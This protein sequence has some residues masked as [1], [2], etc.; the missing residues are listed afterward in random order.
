MVNEMV[1]H[2]SRPNTPKRKRYLKT[3]WKTAKRVFYVL[4]GGLVIAAWI[5]WTSIYNADKKKKADIEK[6]GL[7]KLKDGKVKTYSEASEDMV[8]FQWEDWKLDSLK[9]SDFL[10][11]VLE[12]NG[13]DP[14]IISS[15]HPIT[16]MTNE[17]ELK[18]EWLG[19]KAD[20]W[21]ENRWV[22][23]S[24]HSESIVWKLLSMW[25]N[26]SYWR[27]QSQREAIENGYKNDIIRYNN[28]CKRIANFKLPDKN[29]DWTEMYK[30]LWYSTDEEMIRAIQWNKLD[31]YTWGDRLWITYWIVLLNEQL[32]DRNKWWEKWDEDEVFEKTQWIK[33]KYFA[34][35]SKEDP[36]RQA[37]RRE[38]TDWEK[39]NTIYI[40][41]KQEQWWSRISLGDIK[42]RFESPVYIAWQTTAW[43]STS[44]ESWKNE[45]YL[46]T[47]Q[48]TELNQR[49]GDQI[50]GNDGDLKIEISTGTFWPTSTKLAVKYLKNDL[51]DEILKKTENEKIF[52]DKSFRKEVKDYLNAHPSLMDD[53]KNRAIEEYIQNFQTFFLLNGS[54]ETKE[55]VSN[56]E[57]FSEKQMNYLEQNLNLSFDHLYQW[58]QTFKDYV[59]DE[60]T[61]KK[62]DQIWYGYVRWQKK[63][64]R[65]EIAKILTHKDKFIEFTWLSEKEYNFFIKHHLWP[66][67]LWSSIILSETWNITPENQEPASSTSNEV[68][69][70]Y[71]FCAWTE[72]QEHKMK[73]EQ[74]WIKTEIK[75]SW[76]SNEIN[77]KDIREAIS[78]N[79]KIMEYI[80]EN[81][82]DDEW[83]PITDINQ[84]SDEF[85]YEFLD[86]VVE[87]WWKGVYF[88]TSG[89]NQ[90]IS[91]KNKYRWIA[92]KWDNFCDYLFDLQQQNPDFSKIL[93][94][95]IWKDSIE[96]KDITNWIIR[97][98]IRKSDWSIWENPRKLGA[99]ED[100]II[101][102]PLTNWEPQSI[103]V[104]DI[105]ELVALV[106][107]RVKTDIKTTTD[108]TKKEVKKTLNEQRDTRAWKKKNK[109][110]QN[111]KGKSSV[112]PEQKHS[113][114]QKKG[115]KKVNSKQKKAQKTVGANHQRKGRWRK[116]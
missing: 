30:Q 107:F 105:E 27:F 65:K 47:L 60:N 85:I 37:L 54:E 84:V 70:I 83:N 39:L 114:N 48:I 86:V 45:E 80:Q 33:R 57:R 4:S 7:I 68:N 103:Q 97:Q 100:F 49:F 46:L 79:K 69:T 104:S 101:V 73:E 113:V 53:L 78:N 14:D 108:V 34:S 58:I 43:W 94:R 32:V 9:L 75:L 24:K 40:L 89:V 110:V 102:Y 66:T 61:L 20:E 51:P 29:G 31:I 109:N 96:K 11:E 59:K 62:L 93:K 92:G 8:F 74:K 18:T 28:I 76:F 98:V 77:M 81:C 72:N 90:I 12:R 71:R 44:V 88:K 95:I 19:H 22:E 82:R 21:L 6:H 91:S 115:L 116:K 50:A 35:L 1:N 10:D 16:V 111:S 63:E 56:W 5:G 38:W 25:W 15:V 87:G 3:T 55:T 64:N 23:R 17:N 106:P 36:V 67:I 52:S 26:W 99:G 42:N 41:S 13:F 112:K 2:E